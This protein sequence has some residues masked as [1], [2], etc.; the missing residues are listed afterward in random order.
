MRSRPAGRAK[1]PVG[2]CPEMILEQNL[3]AD[4]DTERA[5]RRQR[6]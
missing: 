6:K 3:E 5:L 2:G 1:C 4:K